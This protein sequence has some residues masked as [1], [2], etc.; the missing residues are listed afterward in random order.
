MA[1]TVKAIEMKKNEGPSVPVSA[2][3]QALA[4]KSGGWQALGNV[5]GGPKTQMTFHKI[6][7]NPW[8]FERRLDDFSGWKIQL[9]AFQRR[10]A[11]ERHGV[12]LLISH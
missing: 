9:A 7:T 2:S 12:I 3:Y 8:P 11:E 1:D 10:S 4:G 6:H 5:V